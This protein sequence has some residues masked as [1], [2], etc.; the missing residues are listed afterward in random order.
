MKVLV[1]S[2]F[3]PKT[4][5]KMKSPSSMRNRRFHPSKCK[6]RFKIWEYSTPILPK[7]KNK[8]TKKLE[9]KGGRD[10]PV[11]YQI[12]DYGR[13]VTAGLWSA[14]RGCPKLPLPKFPFFL[15]PTF[16]CTCSQ[17]LLVVSSTCPP[18]PNFS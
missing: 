11:V 6:A 7:I 16:F 8:K 17:L 5:E 12:A 2:N 15:M 18:Y 10:Q 9:K 14:L 3:R 4:M 13:W 1:Y